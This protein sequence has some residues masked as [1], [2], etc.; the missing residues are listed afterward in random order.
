[1]K[2]K[3]SK[4][5]KSI[6][7]TMK[8]TSVSVSRLLLFATCHRKYYYHYIRDLVPKGL[9]IPF[10]VGSMM[11]FGLELFYNKM[12]SSLVLKKVDKRIDKYLKNYFIP[13]AQT[14]DVDIQRA[15]ILGM[16]KGYMSAYSK[17]PKILKEVKTEKFHSI[18]MEVQPSLPYW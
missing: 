7:P 17:E 4:T 10:Y 5:A 2:K 16:L 13:P 15:V 6:K 12:K 14:G 8:L 11:H 9:Y 3:K 18:D 1:M